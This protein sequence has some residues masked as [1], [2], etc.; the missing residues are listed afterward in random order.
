MYMY[1]S[2]IFYNMGK[3]ILIIKFF[4]VFYDNYFVYMLFVDYYN[5]LYN[6]WYI[7]NNVCERYVYLV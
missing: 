4:V 1:V 2:I 7:C 5:L 3:R 6:Y